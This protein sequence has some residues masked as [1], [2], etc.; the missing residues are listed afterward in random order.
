VLDTGRLLGI[1]TLVDVRKVLPDAWDTVIV[2]ET[3]NP[4]D[5][6]TVVTADEDAAEALNKLTRREVG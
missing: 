1:A 6:L 5:Q 3:M 4:A 2:R